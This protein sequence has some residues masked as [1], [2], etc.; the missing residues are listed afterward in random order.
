MRGLGA[1]E[2]K[3]VSESIRIQSV[4]YTPELNRNVL[5]K[6]QLML[7]GYTV[8]VNGGKCQ[9]YPMFSIPTSNTRNDVTGLTREEVR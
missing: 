1:V 5:S 4:F 8:K 9:I 3:S 7:Q 2:V 6:D